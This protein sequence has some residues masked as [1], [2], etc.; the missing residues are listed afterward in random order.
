[1]T[2][3]PGL[4]S[5]GVYDEPPKRVPLVV[6]KD[7]AQC[8]RNGALLSEAWVV[9]PNSKGVRWVAVWLA[10]DDNGKADHK[11]ALKVHPAL[12]APPKAPLVIDQPCCMFEPHLAILRQGEDLLLK[13]SGTIT[14]NAFIQGGND[15]NVNHILVPG[16]ALLIPA[17]KWKPHY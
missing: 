13:N 5:D 16:K 6:D 3:K 9:D 15:V 12:A 1:M 17:A 7:R 11:A 2:G 4:K 8:L 10:S 14:H